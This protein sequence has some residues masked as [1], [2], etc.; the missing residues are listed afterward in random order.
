MT[1]D[2]IIAA[3]PEMKEV[4]R[5][6]AH[7]LDAHYTEIYVKDFPDSEFHLKLRQNPENKTVVIINS[8]T[9]DPDEKIVETILA[10]GVAKDFG[11]KKIILLATY[12]PYMRQD[13]HFEKYD[14]YSAK[15]ILS[16]FSIFDKVIAIDP[17]LH[18]I[19]HLNL[20]MKKAESISCDE[21]VAKY[22]KDNFKG[23]FE[24]IGPDEESAQ[25]S[26]KIAHLLKKKVFILHKT[27]IGDNKI[28]QEVVKLDSN[29]N[30][31]IIDDIISTG[32][33]LVGAL[34]MAKK[35]GAKKITCIAIHGMLVQEADKKIRKYADIITTNT[36][37]N[38]YYKI[39]ISGLIAERLKKG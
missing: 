29:K 16:L 33:T 38:K 21:I 1:K 6:V 34:K 7:E 23:D 30:Y 27:R 36:I 13:A 9:K 14:S 2:L 25:W 26:G 18:R 19:K 20:I 35:Q 10:G 11:A 4:G 17:H 12:L 37:P 31:I 22:I 24:I 32:K 8:I 15:Q 39:D 3:F 28:K 5:K